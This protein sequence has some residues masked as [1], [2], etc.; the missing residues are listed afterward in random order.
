M[1]KEVSTKKVFISY[2]WTSQ[3]HV[4]NIEQLARR[5]TANGEFGGDQ[6]TMILAEYLYGYPDGLMR[7]ENTIYN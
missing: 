2:A 7:K 5:L 1:T 3:E 6:S 4:D